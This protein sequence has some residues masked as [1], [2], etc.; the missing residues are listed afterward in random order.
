MEGISYLLGEAMH[1]GLHFLL[2][3]SVVILYTLL[4][5]SEQCWLQKILPK[6]DQD[7]EIGFATFA[8]R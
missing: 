3:K 6:N 1:T 4:C 8:A 2:D 5:C 7:L